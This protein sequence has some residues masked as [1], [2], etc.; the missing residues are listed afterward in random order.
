MQRDAPAGPVPGGGYVVSGTVVHGE[1]RGRELGWPTAN[2]QPVGSTVPPDGVYAATVEIED[3]HDGA[4]LAAVSVGDNPTFPGA[5]RTVEA[6]LLDYSGDLYGRQLVVRLLHK[7]RDLE[8]YDS[9]ED[10]ITAISADV[11]RTRALLGASM[12]ELPEGH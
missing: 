4:Y 12:T 3:A 6:H 9:L 5:A 7:L 10:L 1:H 2:V 8:A 11:D